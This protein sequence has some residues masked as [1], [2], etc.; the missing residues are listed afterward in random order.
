M[1][2][3]AWRQHR[4]QLVAGAGLLALLLA[5]LLT[6]GFGIA[7][8]FRSS[9][10]AGCLALP[11]GHCDDLANAFGDRYSNLQ[12]LVPL[13]LVLP[14][15]IGLFW[16]APLVA[17]EFEQGTH[18]LAWT[19]GV[20]RL[21]WLGVKL[22]VLAGATAVGVAVLTWV[23]TWW[24]RPLVIAADNRLNPGPFDLRGI[25][26]IAYALFALALGVAAG[27]FVRRVVPA[28]AA[29]VAVF[30]ATRAAVAIWLRPHFAA[31]KTAS[32]PFLERI[33]GFG[34]GD[35]ILSTTTVDGRG[36]FM[37]AGSTLNFNLL[38]QRCPA[39]VPR[40]GDLPDPTAL[41]ECIHRIGLH[42]VARYQP[43]SRFWMFQG[44][45][46][47]IFVALAVALFALATLWV[48][49]RVA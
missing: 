21:R 24:S 39:L 2:W 47:G 9:G 41:R 26:P 13:F 29:T 20:T 25:V 27:T 35:W 30:A 37:G 43:G 31:V 11:G 3:V 15:V 23:L 33:T 6:T 45:E 18:R 40:K 4:A 14:A 16:G 34:Q 12:F 7:S 38:S 1:I 48:R 46:T 22:A 36:R 49:R 44:I 10:L 19:Q 28:M 17:R 5:F 32:F 8:A 42:V